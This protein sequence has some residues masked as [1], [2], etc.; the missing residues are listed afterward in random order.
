[1][2]RVITAICVQER[3]HQRV[4]IDLDGEYVF[5]LS[6]IVGAW[7]KVG[8]HISDEKI[9]TLKAQDS[10]EVAFQSALRLLNRRLRSSEEIRKGLIAKGFEPEQVD[11]IIQ[12]LI[13]D[14]L[15]NDEKFMHSWI[16]SRSHF[17]PRSRR[18]LK[19]ELRKKGIADD[20]IDTA[21]A[22][23]VEDTDLAYQAAT[24][25]ARRLANLE[26]FEFRKRL[27]AFLG[28]RGFSYGTIVPVV[29]TVWEEQ[30]QQQGNPGENEGS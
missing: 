18:L 11:D 9:A 16:E 29:N 15:L 23:S 27:S 8:D 6:R 22:D 26:W 25:Y 10:N 2:D 17:H 20:L 5:G 21:L 24:Q 3:N 1:M 12:R 7:L 13:S 19:L 28:R 30:N 14:K 4:S